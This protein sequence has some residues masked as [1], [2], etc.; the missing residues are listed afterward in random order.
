[1]H[2]SMTREKNSDGR[3]MIIFSRSV[4]SIVKGTSGTTEKSAVSLWSFPCFMIAVAIGMS[5]FGSINGIQ[6]ESFSSG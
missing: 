6:Q 4:M 3:Y 1:M 2:N 5:D